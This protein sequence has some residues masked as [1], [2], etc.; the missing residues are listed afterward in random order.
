MK[1][2]RLAATALTAIGGVGTALADVSI[3]GYSRFNY[4]SWSDEGANTGGANDT[5]MNLK[6]AVTFSGTVMADNGLKLSG[7]QT[8]SAS[9]GGSIGSD[10][11]AGYLD[12]GGDFGN[13]RFA[14][15]DGYGDDGATSADV[16]ADEG[17]TAGA[18]FDGDSAIDSDSGK[19][20]LSYKSPKVNGFQVNFGTSDA[21]SASKADA[22]AWG[23]SYS[24]T[25]MGAGVTLR[26]GSSSTADS[27]GAAND[28]FSS[29][30]AAVVVSADALTLTLAQ[31]TKKTDGN[32]YAGTGVGVTYQATDELK[33][34]LHSKSAEDSKD[35]DYDY[36]ETA[37]SAS[38]SFAKGLM[39]HV[40]YTDWSYTN[41]AGSKN[42]GN[43]TNLELQVSF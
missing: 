6:T 21:G 42:G 24:A 19:V 23:V 28:D 22:T 4:T 3:S 29:T 8:I 9:N 40:T 35:A 36:G 43:Y 14:D 12:I 5:A 2:L 1:K 33:L 39:G 37:L 13:L 38:Y 10:G 11:N 31:N 18:P 25:T 16:A 34:A 7:G 32:S 17:T 15:G 41:G 30:S 20:S 27:T 26:Y